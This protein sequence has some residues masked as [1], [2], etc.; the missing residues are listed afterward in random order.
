[1]TFEVREDLET[2]YVIRGVE[3]EE[4]FALKNL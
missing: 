2:F 4:E 1:V 3:R